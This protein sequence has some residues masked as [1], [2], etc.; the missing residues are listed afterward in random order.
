LS[1]KKPIGR[2]WV[3]QG[4]MADSFGAGSRIPGGVLT[5]QRQFRTYERELIT[6]DFRSI[7]VTKRPSVLPSLRFTKPSSQIR[8]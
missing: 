2:R 6:G 7:Q 4:S 3:I 5:N 8:R 1:R